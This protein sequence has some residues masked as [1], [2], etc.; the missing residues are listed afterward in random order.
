MTAA[1]TYRLAVQDRTGW[2]LGLDLFQV[3]VVTVGLLAASL[4]AARDAY[5]AGLGVV[6][7]SLAAAFTRV[8]GQSLHHVA[9]PLA[10][11]VCRQALGRH[12][13]F[14]PVTGAA[15]GS[16]QLPRGLSAVHVAAVPAGPLARFVGDPEVALVTDRTSHRTAVSMRISGGGFALAD[17]AEQDRFCSGWGDAL[18]ACASGSAAPVAVQVTVRVAP[19]AGMPG[20]SRREAIV[21]VVGERRRRQRDTDPVVAEAAR[22]GDRLVAAGL[23]VDGAL[24]EAGW[25]TAVREFCDPSGQAERALSLGERAGVSQPAHAGPL[26]V[27][28]DWTAVRVDGSWHR[29]YLVADWPRVEVPASWLAGLLLCDGPTWTLTL[30]FEPVPARRARQ[31]VERQAAKL[32]SDEEQRRRAGFR[33]GAMHRRHHEDLEERE[34]ELVAGHAEYEYAGLVVVSA[35]TLAALDDGGA[36]LVAAAAGSGVELRP[37]HGR[38]LRGLGCSLPVPVG[39]HRKAT[40]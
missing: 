10:A 17:P 16:P 9:G 4:L 6:L 25:A 12:R 22:L 18:A 34:A 39:L 15:G 28:E 13:W 37:L 7:L 8:G 26:A 27:A 21:T 36:T 33:I 19:E 14:A 5:G 35:T 3:S 23:S 24:D 38:H 2:F 40:R 32:S 1:R 30:S 11:F 20:A 29:A 31:A